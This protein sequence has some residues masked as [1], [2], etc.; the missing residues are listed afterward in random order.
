MI[1][2]A[3]ELA[4]LPHVPVTALEPFQGNLKDLSEREYTKLKK[5]IQENGVIVPFF[6]WQE[7]GKLLDGHQRQRVFMREGWRVDVPV[8][9]ISAADEQD[10]KRKL[11]VISSQY[12]RVTQE[13][14]DGFTFDLD[15]EWL[16]DTV[17]FDALP[18][19]FGEW[20]APAE[21][22]ES[23]DAEPQVNR[24][25]E[26]SEEWG[27]ETGQLWRLPS[28][29]P[30]QEHRLICGDCT[31]AAVVERVMGGEAADAVITD[32]PYAVFGS[33]TG[34]GKNLSDDNM[35]LPFCREVYRVACDN[36]PNNAHVY[37]HCDWKSFNAWW[38]QLSRFDLRPLNCIVWDKGDGGIGTNYTSRHEFVLF[39]NREPAQMTMTESSR[40]MR[41]VYG[42]ANVQRFNVTQ[43]DDRQ[44]NAAKPVK[45]IEVFV[46]ASTD[47]GQV[48][49][50]PFSG[51][52]TTIIAAENLTRQCRAV[53]ISPAYVAVALQRYQDAFGIEPELIDG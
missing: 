25:E 3:L 32:P 34:I 28:R 5:S 33:S 24:A 6:V 29:T 13:G 12:G 23:A 9:Y 48:I 42:I 30:G 15:D 53:E 37:I 18:F 51:S 20:G 8:V 26:L 39:F 49:L 14:W 35:I 47:M 22:P 43:G 2:I 36:T 31:D 16:Q 27:V 41:L 45:L 7:T 1:D 40:G 11:L 50:E 44:H 4:D 52:G 38:S 10:A 46:K 17:N 21:E 19:V